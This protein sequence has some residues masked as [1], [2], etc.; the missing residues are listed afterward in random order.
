[1]AGR[2]I[3]WLYRVE[4]LPPDVIVKQMINHLG[5]ADFPARL[6]SPPPPELDYL[7]IFEPQLG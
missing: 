2:L 7:P 3:N 4:D 6:L 1:M 5:V